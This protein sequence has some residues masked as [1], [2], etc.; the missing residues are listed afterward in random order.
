[1]LLQ[2]LVTSRT[3]HELGHDPKIVRHKQHRQAEFGEEIA[4]Q[5]E[6]FAAGSLRRA[7]SS[8]RRAG[9]CAANE[10]P[11]IGKHAEFPP[12]HP[13]HA[14]SVCLSPP[15]RISLFDRARSPHKLCAMTEGSVA[16]P[17]L[18]AGLRDRR[19]FLWPAAAQARSAST[20]RISLPWRWSSMVNQMPNLVQSTGSSKL[21]ARVRMSAS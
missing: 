9:F 16:D 7:L 12:R 8:A 14:I 13:H 15:L 3:R 6:D 4:Q 2:M 18:P 17:R 1:M 11:R 20:R 21:S 19:A 5:I 10:H